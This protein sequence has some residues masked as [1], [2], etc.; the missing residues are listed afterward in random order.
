MARF[1]DMTG[2]SIVNNQGCEMTIVNY[3]NSKDINVMFSDDTIIKNKTYT[4]FLKKSI[5]NP[6][7]RDI[8]GIGYFG[9]GKYKAYDYSS[10]KQN[11]YNDIYVMWRNMFERCY[12][13]REGYKTWDS[14]K[15]VYVD[16][17]FH[18]FQ[19]FAK[20]YNENKWSSEILLCLDKDILFKGNKI[21]SKETCILVP[22]DINKL[23][24]SPS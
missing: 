14:Y 2:A 7:N 12:S 5:F 4:S 3:K 1:K 9:I 15:N 8:Y 10:N 20:W 19:D 23:F 24:S 11:N 22:Q 17:S 18:C 16:S 6:N 13:D 21:Y